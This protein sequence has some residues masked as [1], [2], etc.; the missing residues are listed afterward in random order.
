MEV[1]LCKFVRSQLFIF[2]SFIT[3]NI[4]DVFNLVVS[5][6]LV[7]KLKKHFCSLFICMFHAVEHNKITE[8]YMYHTKQSCRFMHVIRD[9]NIFI[10]KHSNSIDIEKTYYSIFCFIDEVMS[11]SKIWVIV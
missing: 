11:K 7:H 1:I 10:I 6:I 3:S 9:F 4:K 2:S 8:T 5:W